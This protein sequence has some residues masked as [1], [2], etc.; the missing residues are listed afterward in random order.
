MFCMRGLLTCYLH[1]RGKIYAAILRVQ[2]SKQ[3]VSVWTD[4][5]ASGCQG[6]GQLCGKGALANTSFARQ[7]Q[8]LVAHAAQSLL[9]LC[10]L[11]VGAFRCRGACCLVGAPRAA[12]C[13]ARLLTLCAWTICTAKRQY[14]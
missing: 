4:L 8:Y 13:I 12:G 11:G 2:G 10:N 3:I 5:F 1:G 9:Y 6:K 14:A 7:H